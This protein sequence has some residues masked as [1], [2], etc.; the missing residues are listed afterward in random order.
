MDTIDTAHDTGTANPSQEQIWEH[1]AENPLNPLVFD[2]KVEQD[3]CERDSLVHWFETESA[4]I[5]FLRNILDNAIEDEDLFEVG[6]PMQLTHKV[7]TKVLNEFVKFVFKDISGNGE[8]GENLC[9]TLREMISDWDEKIW[10][11]V[12]QRHKNNLRA[13]IISRGVFVPETGRHKNMA[14]TLAE[15]L[16][17]VRLVSGRNGHETRD[18]EPLPESDGHISGVQDGQEYQEEEAE[19]TR[20]GVELERPIPAGNRTEVIPQTSNEAQSTSIVKGSKAKSGQSSSRTRLHG[21]D[22]AERISDITKAISTDVMYS[23][24]PDES[25]MEAVSALQDATLLSKIDP[26]N[27]HAALIVFPLILRDPARQVFRKGIGPYVT[28]VKEACDALLC[29]F[30]PDEVRIVN[31]QIWMEISL[32]TMPAESNVQKLEQLVRK[33][34][35]L[36]SN[37]TESRD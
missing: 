36:E 28:T 33:M 21:Y 27:N 6:M 19:T 7:Q 9:N 34:D 5:S 4:D 25:L 18:G 30:L 2:W 8:Q 1:Y 31:D 32:R 10:A 20:D 35:N 23:G 17:D 29:E 22:G 24:A 11:R 12:H 16:R 3:K 14:V 15:A 26:S 37:L 13:S